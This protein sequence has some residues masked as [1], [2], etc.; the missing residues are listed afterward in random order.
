MAYKFK[1]K[2]KNASNLLKMS[3]DYTNSKN[4]WAINSSIIFLQLKKSHNEMNFT[5]EIYNLNYSLKLKKLKT[6]H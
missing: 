6:L 5:S 2:V 3:K 4:N 1:I